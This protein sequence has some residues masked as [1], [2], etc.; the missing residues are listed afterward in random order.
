MKSIIKG[1][2]SSIKNRNLVYKLFAFYM[3]VYLS[4]YLMLSTG[5]SGLAKIAGMGDNLKNFN[6]TYLML[7][8]SKHGE[9]QPMLLSFVFFAF[10]IYFFYSQFI[11]KSYLENLSGAEKSW[12]NYRKVLLSWIYNIPLIIVTLVLLGKL[13]MKS[14]NTVTE[15]PTTASII[16]YIFVALIPI[17]FIFLMALLDSTRI[18]TVKEKK[19]SFKAF[20]ASAALSLKKYPMFVLIYV[21]YGI[22]A[23]LIFYI[24]NL[25]TQFLG[26]KLWGQVLI[27]MF[28]HFLYLMFQLFV[29]FSIMGSEFTLI[30]SHYKKTEE[31][32]IKS[33]EE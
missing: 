3:F 22:L 4:V 24:Y 28:F 27:L 5:L 10:I 1:F 31:K 8:L 23:L 26:A 29:K 25:I 19:S 7:Y 9:I 17:L 6:F 32:E 16:Y 13:Y 18:I 12:K 30:D 33:E 2:W 21:F 14:R 15:N 11:V 20:L